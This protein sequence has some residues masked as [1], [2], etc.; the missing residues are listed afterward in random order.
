[1]VEILARIGGRVV[2]HWLKRRYSD[3]GSQSVRS[4]SGD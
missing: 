3:E 4:V 2:R 1:M